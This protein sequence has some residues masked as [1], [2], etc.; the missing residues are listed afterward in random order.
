MNQNRCNLLLKVGLALL[1]PVTIEQGAVMMGHRGVAPKN[2]FYA[3]NLTGVVMAAVGLNVAAA[4][5]LNVVVPPVLAAGLFYGGTIAVIKNYYDNWHN[6]NDVVKLLSLLLALGLILF[7][8]LRG[9]KNGGSKASSGAA[10]GANRRP[11]G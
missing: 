1:L 8:V 10:H 11:R 4:I 5:G 9:R 3:V 2:L 6:I 7:L